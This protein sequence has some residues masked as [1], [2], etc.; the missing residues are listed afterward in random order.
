M[1]T[2][3]S[4]DSPQDLSRAAYLLSR[5][6]EN[7]T[8]A[9]FLAPSWHLC[10]EG[11][12]AG[13][14]EVGGIGAVSRCDQAGW[15]RTTDG[16]RSTDV[17]LTGVALPIRPAQRRSIRARNLAPQHGSGAN[18][19]GTGHLSRARENG[20]CANFVGVAGEP[21][22]ILGSSRGPCPGQRRVAQP[23]RFPERRNPAKNPGTRLTE[24][25]PKPLE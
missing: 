25:V 3:G 6:S 13:R 22:Q 1:T 24:S 7:G 4:G 21:C 2:P 17:R 23:Q 10:Q 9:S 16:G 12:T 20:S 15:Q 18:L 14:P 11:G 8:C 19:S 5:A